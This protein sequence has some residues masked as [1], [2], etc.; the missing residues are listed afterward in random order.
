[1]RSRIHIGVRKYEM[2]EIVYKQWHGIFFYSSCKA[3]AQAG[4]ETFKVEIIEIEHNHP[5]DAPRKV[6]S[7]KRARPKTRQKPKNLKKT[8]ILEKTVAF[9][10]TEKE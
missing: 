8:K 9:V 5:R 4:K 10:K 7:S 1:M 6:R 2:I 3:K